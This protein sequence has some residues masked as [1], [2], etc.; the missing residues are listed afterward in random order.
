M[1]MVLRRGGT[2]I[3]IGCGRGFGISGSVF[4][5]VGGGGNSGTIKSGGGE[6]GQS[7]GGGGEAGMVR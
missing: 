4:E 5:R 6:L 1:P 3:R 7:G 2:Q